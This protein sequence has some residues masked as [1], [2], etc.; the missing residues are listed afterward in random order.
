MRAAELHTEN[1]ILSVVYLDYCHLNIKCGNFT[2]LF[3]RRRHGSACYAARAASLFFSHS[4]NQ[5]LNLLLS[6]PFTLSMLKLPNII[7][8]F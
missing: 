4:I 2:L 7:C 1:E 6:L 3:Y 5:I 8:F